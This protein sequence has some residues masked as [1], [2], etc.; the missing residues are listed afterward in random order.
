MK[1]R[2]RK[3]DRHT[4]IFGLGLVFLAMVSYLRVWTIH[5]VMWDDNAWLMSMY[6]SD[7]LRTFLDT[8]FV[9]MRR[10]PQGVFLYALFWLHKNTD[11]YFTVWH[12]LNT[13]TQVGTPLLLYTFCLRIFDNQRLLAFLVAASLVTI[14]LDQTLPHASSVNYRIGL[15]LA[16]AS[17]QMTA[18]AMQSKRGIWLS[19]MSIGLAVLAYTVFME[20]IVALEP[21]RLAVIAHL[22][23]RRH[24]TSGRALVRSSLVKWLPFLL[25]CV[26]FVV[27]RLL[28]RSYG[29]YADIYQPDFLFWLNWQDNIN[30]LAMLLFLQW[31]IFLDHVNEA[32]LWTFAV[33]A[34]SMFGLFAVFRI[35]SVNSSFS[36][37][38]ALK[39][40]HAR[41][42]ARR[43][44]SLGLAL[45]VPVLLLFQFY[46]RT[47]TWGLHSS[48]G[49]IGQFGYALVIGS[50]L[51][52]MLRMFAEKSSRLAMYAGAGA[53]LLFALGVFFNNLNIDLYRSVHRHLDEFWTA[54]VQRFP[55]P[56]QETAFLIDAKLDAFYVPRYHGAYELPLNLLY[57]T[58][59]EPVEFRRHRVM[60]LDESKDIIMGLKS[61]AQLNAARIARPTS[62]GT[63]FL[64]PAKFIVI[65][66]DKSGLLINREILDKFPSTPYRLILDKDVPELSK[67]ED[68][69]YPLRYK[70][71]TMP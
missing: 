12:S 59:R 22:L 3:P 46:G 17:F 51:F 31:A 37:V 36:G 27:Y 62:W 68:G 28:A 61:N 58:S 64:E 30:L 71:L 20:A 5:G 56:P 70:A 45:M 15:F 26:P 8:G 10:I 11:L 39:N 52:L 4:V 19:A 42:A 6:S 1:T 43:A 48:H 33:A 57:A 32:S 55:D 29:A 67:K 13:V 44:F 38:L 7:D 49:A 14:P 21:G 16:V 9:E 34:F 63:D 50:S 54:F 24:G 65:Y 66:Y 41:T 40:H 69:H 18:M 25:A 60:V 35:A 2:V 23:N 47:I 53:G